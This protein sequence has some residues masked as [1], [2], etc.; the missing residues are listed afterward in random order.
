[1][2]RIILN[3]MTYRR[4][5]VKDAIDDRVHQIVENWCLIWVVRTYGIHQNFLKHWVDEL[6]AQLDPGLDKLRA[7]GLSDRA[8]RKLV[9]E[10]LIDDARLDETAIVYHMIDKK[11]FREGLSA[12]MQSEAS[13][14]WTKEGLADIR[15]VYNLE[16]TERNLFHKLVGDR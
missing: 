2:L 10:V 4:P 3:E 14:A 16:L 11:F 12:A 13:E 1:M 9:D 15:A 6:L 8:K 7:S 5:K